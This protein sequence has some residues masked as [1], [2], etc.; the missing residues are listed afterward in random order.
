MSDMDL[1][2]AD[3]GWDDRCAAALP[4]DLVPARVACGHRDLW[5]V[6]GA[7]P[8]R[9]CRLAGRLRHAATGPSDLPAAGDWVGLDPDGSVIRCVLPRRGALSRADPRT[10]DELVLAANV[11]VV[12]VVTSAN[13]DL[14]ARRLERF[15]ALAV[16]ARAECV[17]VLNKADLVDDPGPAIAAV[18][19][20]VGGA[21]PVVVCSAAT[22]VGV[23]AVAAW[24][25]R[26]RTVALL[27]TSGVGKSTLANALLGADVQAT[28]PIRA[29]DDRGRHTTVRRELLVLPGGGLLVD[30]PGLKL[31]RMAAEAGAGLATAFDDL[32]A[33][34]T[35]C[36]YA[37]CRHDGEP[38]CAVAAAI[39]DGA[40][41]PARLDALRRL[42]REERWARERAD[43]EGRAARRARR[44]EINL[45]QRRTPPRWER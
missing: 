15:A 14:N 43:P 5:T 11:D 36:R 23:D 18:R 2:P 44:R 42:E 9:L 37:D 39:E 21:V 34:A 31:P 28:A 41:D 25:T 6:L 32:G 13:R 33:L 16:A 1:R 40:L 45:A 30:T 29:V 26:G 7:G 35:G 20:A 38:G 24:A 4:A 12:L 22:G 10:G 3:L 17:A 27:G 8:P 19:A